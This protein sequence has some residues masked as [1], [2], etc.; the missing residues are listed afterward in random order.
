MR[1]ARLVLLLFL[2]ACAP[3]VLG[4]LAP[5]QE[6]LWNSAHQALG[7]QQYAVADSLFGELVRRYPVTLAGRES[8][9]YL[10]AIHLDPRNPAW[11]P[12]PAERRLRQYISADTAG[13]P[14]VKR[15]P[16]AEI[17]LQLAHQLNLPSE[18]RI[19]GL[20][21]KVIVE[22]EVTTVP[23]RV[24]PAG[25]AAAL[26]AENAAL[27]TQLEARDQTIK[28]L[29]DELERIRRTLTRHQ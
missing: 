29:E 20:R 15:R 4:R 26:A 8:L 22:R 24:A 19:S 6:S 10:G 21:P 27:R 13:A 14:D 3:N 23:R 18:D 9:F 2:G 12:A 17:L 7:A 28:R 1:Y 5:E 25:E 16:E 11:D